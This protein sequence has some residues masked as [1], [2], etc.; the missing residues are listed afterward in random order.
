MS[1]EGRGLVLR[2]LLLVAGM[3]V[4]ATVVLMIL[5]GRTGTGSAPRDEL[6][7]EWLTVL[8]SPVV[9]TFPGNLSWV[10]LGELPRALPSGPGWEIRYNAT[11]A[12]ARR[13]ST[14]LPLNTVREMLDE[15]QQMRNFRAP[16]EGGGTVADEAAAR[17]TIVNTLKALSE[18]W[19][20][21][22]VEERTH[23]A[24]DPSMTAVRREV[25]E[26]AKSPNLV[27]KSEAERTRKA[28]DQ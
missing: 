3:G 11:L 5:L 14:K 27:L 28:L 17:R 7:I 18:W 4:L 20:K 25:D 13:S 21:L 19:Q 9:E 23:F 2:G 26:L 1:Q 15:P 10:A 16:L 6:Q 24:M 8:A 22:P 12:L